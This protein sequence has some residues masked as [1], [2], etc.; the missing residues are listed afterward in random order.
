MTTG[1]LAVRSESL[2]GLPSVPFSENSGA[3]WPTSR[4]TAALART[5]TARALRTRARLTAR[6]M[7]MAPPWSVTGKPTSRAGGSARRHSRTRAGLEYRG[8]PRE[9]RRA[10]R[11]ETGS[12][13]SWA[14]VRGGHNPTGGDDED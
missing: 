1:P 12:V 13:P 10:V 14:R 2:T 5:R 9:T 8:R 3:F 4:A 7:D 6:V 11:R